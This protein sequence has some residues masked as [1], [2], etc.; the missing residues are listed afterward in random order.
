MLI[1]SIQLKV[2]GISLKYSLSVFQ[3]YLRVFS[4]KNI[5]PRQISLLVAFILTALVL[6]ILL[7]FKILYGPLFF[8][9]AIVF[10]VTYFIIDTILER[11]IYRKIKLIYKFIAQTKA[12]KREEFYNQELLP[13]KTIEEAREEVIKW[14]EERKLEI[15]RLESNVEFRKEFLMNLAHELKTPIFT[16]QGYLETI[17]DG[18]VPDEQ[19][20]NKF[21]QNAA[22]SIDRLVDLVDDLDT[23]SKLES[24]Q[25]PLQKKSFVIQSLIKEVFD[26]LQLKADAK[27]IEL[28]IKKGCES[29]IA[30]MAD[31]QK[32]KQVLVNLIENSIKY[33]KEKGTTHAGIYAVDEYSVYIEITDDGTGIADEH[34]SRVFERFYRTDAARSRQVGGSGLGLAIVKHIIEAHGH[35][36]TCRSKLDVG[37]SFGFTINKA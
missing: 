5:S 19:L 28:S 35:T 23:I 1:I 34:I 10:T 3:V 29:P 12:T 25:I 21:L 7:Y 18:N 27:K 32:I 31:Q 14:A 33:G 8:S 30:V 36:V 16:A 4:T 9:L 26:E 15:E 11:F 13:P 20:R 24:N 37:S 22:S 2:L 6:I 17:I